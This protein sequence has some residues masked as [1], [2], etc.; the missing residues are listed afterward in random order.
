VLFDIG[1][2]GEGSAEEQFANH[3]SRADQPFKPCKP[4]NPANY[5]DTP[6][7]NPERLLDA[8]PDGK[9]VGT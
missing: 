7:V 8:R 4:L 1:N 6:D 3:L 2:D 9:A 5:P